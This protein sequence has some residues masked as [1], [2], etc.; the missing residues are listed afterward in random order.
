MSTARKIF[1]NTTAQFASK[2]VSSLLSILI[3]KLVTQYLGNQ[4]TGPYGEYTTAFSYLS[5]FVIVADMGLFT[6]GVREMS[7]DKEKIPM[8]VGNIMAFRTIVAV[9]MI[10]IAIII[11]FFIPKYQG[12][13]IPL[14]I[15]IASVSS[16]L[17]L[18][19]STISSVQQVHLKM[20]YNALSTI[21]EKVVNVICLLLVIYVMYPGNI[22]D[23]FNYLIWAGVAGD[24][25][26]FGMNYYF[27]RKL[28]PIRFRID[29]EF[30]RSVLITAL[31]YGAALVLNNIYF[32]IGSILVSLIKNSQEAAVYNL[33]LRIL[34]NIGM[35]PAFLM[36]AVLPTLT[37]SLIAKDGSHKRI[38]QLSFDCLVMSSMPIIAGTI[39]LSAPLVLLMSN[40]K[41]LT[42]LSKGYIGSDL[43][44]AILIIATAFSFVNMLFG[45]IIVADNHQNKLL[46]RNTFG[47]L[48]T[49][50]LGLVVI[51]YFGVTGAAINN[52][53]AEFY[54]AVA[55]YFIAKHY[56]KF[57]IK[58]KNA[59]KT[60]FSAIVMGVS[61]YFLRGPTFLFLR[62]ANLLVLIPIGGI[63]YFGLLYATGAINQ[64]VLAMIK[65]S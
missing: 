48:I 46:I 5:T 1:W 30:W 47:A 41:Y 56:V 42:D 13:H 43:I 18:L 50:V 11:S 53:I 33:P 27:S 64:E 40:A 65:K 37:R 45:Y 39:A 17:N 57:D 6:V 10:G 25:A 26:M 15:M 44:L 35:L 49:L 60:V 14:A 55:S 59:F 20:Q 24:A 62:N 23:G 54:V 8:I 21:V 32:N 19:T 3:I 31:P 38:I 52:V 58:L 12:T 29:R 2:I 16:V 36:N 34:E 63:I 22:N 9:L 7:K 4:D 51:P 28:T 61:V